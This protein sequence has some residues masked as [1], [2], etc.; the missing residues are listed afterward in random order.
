MAWTPPTTVRVTE[1]AATWQPNGLPQAIVGEPFESAALRSPLA[2]H[3]TAWFHAKD[4]WSCTSRVHLAP[5]IRPETPLAA[6]PAG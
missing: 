4:F 3:Q 6:K 1:P 2:G 5:R